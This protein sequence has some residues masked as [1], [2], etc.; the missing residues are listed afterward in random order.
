MAVYRPEILRLSSFGFLFML[1]GFKMF[2][3]LLLCF[4]HRIP[5]QKSNPTTLLTHGLRQQALEY[6]YRVFSGQTVGSPEPLV[7]YLDVRR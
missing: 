3:C 5:L 6:K 7:D 4:V 1:F 2:I